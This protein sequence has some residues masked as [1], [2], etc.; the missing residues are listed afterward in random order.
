M[1]AVSK[2]PYVDVARFSQGIESH[3]TDI[4]TLQYEASNKGADS[5]SWNI[6]APGPRSLMDSQVE[7]R[8]PI[9]INPGTCTRFLR[10]G[11]IKNKYQ[12]QKWASGDFSSAV[13]AA[14]AADAAA[15]D[16]V[17]FRTVT[18]VGKN[19]NFGVAARETGIWSAVSSVV[20]EINGISLIPLLSLRI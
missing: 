17:R 3:V 1:A 15:Q 9:V 11:S 18:K 16:L 20:I 19:R 14:D 13:Y 2:S 12:Q 10:M 7:L 8:I 5:L 6:R 4:V